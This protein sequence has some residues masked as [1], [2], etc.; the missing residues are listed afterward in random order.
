[1]RTDEDVLEEIELAFASCVR[2][3]H[4][5]NYTHC[6]ECAEHDEL[7]RARDRSNLT[8]DDVGNPGWD[9]M[10]F[11][12][13]EGKAYFIP[14][15]ARISLCTDTIEHA[16]YRNQLVFHLWTGG[17]Y[18]EFY[19]YCNPVQQAAI[20]SLL[21]HYVESRPELAEISADQ[22]FQAIEQWSS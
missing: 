21:K 22:I 8:L 3:K 11:C 5:T 1:M 18:N 12:S 7:L 14:A 2:P 4:F 9:P 16:Y 6:E 13:P 17:P 10:C 19:Q 20:A 15:L